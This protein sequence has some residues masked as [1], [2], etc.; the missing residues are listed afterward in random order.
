M[1]EDIAVKA[2]EI[3][4]EFDT[5][6]CHVTCDAIL[7]YFLL[8]NGFHKLAETYKNKGLRCDFDYA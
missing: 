1:T 5:E 7:Y 6:L 4:D 2:I 3:V 8:E